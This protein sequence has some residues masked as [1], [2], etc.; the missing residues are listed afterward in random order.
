MS[1]NLNKIDSSKKAPN[2]F[3]SV[4]DGTGSPATTSTVGP[5]ITAVVSNIP[6]IPPAPPPPP[7]A[8]FNATPLAGLFPLTVNFEDTSL[9]SPTAWA[10]DFDNDGIYDSTEQNPTFT[11]SEPGTYSVK[12]TAISPYGSDTIIKSSY[13]TVEQEPIVPLV[14]EFSVDVTSGLAPLTV[15]FTDLSLGNPDEWEW[16]FGNEGTSSDRNPTWIFSQSGIY[17][18]TLI[19]RRN[20]GAETSTIVKENLIE[21]SIPQPI[22]TTYWSPDRKT[23]G[24]I[25]SNDNLTVTKSGSGLQGIVSEH[26]AFTKVYWEISLSPIGY[27]STIMPYVGIFDGEENPEFDPNTNFRFNQF[28]FGDVI[29]VAYSPTEGNLWFGVNGTWLNGGD[30]SNNLNPYFNNIPTNRFYKAYVGT[31][32]GDALNEFTANFGA[33]GYQYGKPTGFSEYVQTELVYE[34]SFNP[35]DNLGMSL[36]NDNLTAFS[37]WNMYS[38]I[39]GNIGKN[40]GKWYWEVYIRYVDGSNTCALGVVNQDFTLGDVSGPNQMSMFSG[41]YVISNSNITNM[42]G[43]SF[44]TDDVMMFALDLDDR[45]LYV[46]KNGTWFN[47]SNPVTGENPNFDNF[48]IIGDMYPYFAAGFVSTISGVTLRSIPEMIIYSL[49]A[50][51]LLLEN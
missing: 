18:I 7:V 43:N 27:T 35:L 36:Q 1:D 39:R 19:V 29:M 14:A 13:I 20:N 2:V 4:T 16:D 40:S 41:G 12:L 45:K 49:P 17:T 37:P 44:V 50:G 48:S 47:N 22:E 25:L 10:W 32:G 8:N 21:V 28:E 42:A 26:F 6:Y 5:G 51:Y 30:P 46:G 3:M 38:G 9:N 34:L 33:L 24:F 15:Q 11:Y 23:S 31:A